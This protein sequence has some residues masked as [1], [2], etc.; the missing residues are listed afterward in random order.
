MPR[1]TRKRGARKTGKTRAFL[2]HVAAEYGHGHIRNIKLDKVY[3]I[4]ES[5]APKFDLHPGSA[6]NALRRA[7]LS[8]R[9]EI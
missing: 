5:C 2:D 8:A 1:R 6:R 3:T 9:G 4:S 7:I